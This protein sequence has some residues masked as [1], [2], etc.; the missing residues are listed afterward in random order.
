MVMSIL[1][2]F[3]LPQKFILHFERVLERLKKYGVLINPAKCIGVKDVT[4][5]GYRVSSQGIQPTEEKIQAIQNYPVPKT[6]KEL[7]RFLGIAN[8][9]RRL[10]PNAAQTQAPLNSALRGNIK[11]SK[12]IDMHPERI[13]AFEETKTQLAKATLL[14]HPRS[15]AEIALFTGASDNAIGAVLQQ[16]TTNNWEPLGFFSKTLT[17]SQKNYSPYDREL[18]FYLRRNQILP[19]HG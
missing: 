19:V 7:R 11:G 18:P 12:K 5:L 1:F 2:K 17:P 4:F 14:A 9:Y 15:E 13:K 6:A 16:R 8:F 10:I 3:S